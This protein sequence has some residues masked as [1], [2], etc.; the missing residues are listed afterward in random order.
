MLRTAAGQG[1]KPYMTLGAAARVL[2]VTKGQLLAWN[3]V[4]VV[5]QNGLPSVPEW[6]VD[7]VVVR[8]MPLLSDVFSGEALELCL[9]TMRPYGD[10][11]TGVDALKAH[12]WALVLPML[13][14]FRRK[15]DQFMRAERVSDW[16][17]SV[18]DAPPEQ[19]AP[20]LI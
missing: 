6:C 1:V 19:R 10:T 5:R 17:A 16:L 8:V 13:R 14:E 3:M 18:G 12:D 15:F 9:T 11:R 4:L 20:L 7:P 2:K